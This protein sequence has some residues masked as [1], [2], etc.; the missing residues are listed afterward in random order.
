MAQ[1]SVLNNLFDKYSG[2]EGYTSIYITSY[3][4]ELLASID[5][6]DKDLQSAAQGIQSIKMLTVNTESGITGIEA[7]YSEVLAALPNTSYKDLMVVKD[8]AQEITFKVREKDKKITE[9]VMLVKD[10]KE[11]LLMF[12]E[13]NIDLKS[14]AKMSKSVDIEGFGHLEKVDDQTK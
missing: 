11:P 1:E 6:E 7:F 12:I 2:K 9:L 4:F 5:E 8:G 14:L 3:M 10:A 13:G